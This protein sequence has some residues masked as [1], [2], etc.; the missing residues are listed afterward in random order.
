M[1]PE[2]RQQIADLLDSRAL[3][4]MTH[5]DGC[6]AEHIHCAAR[7]L[8]REN[9]HMRADIQ[10]LVAEHDR[11]KAEDDGVDWT[12]PLIDGPLRAYLIA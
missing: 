2:T 11:A 1:S 12:A 10:L 6:H 5:W 4:G 7:M 3:T 8:L 9:T